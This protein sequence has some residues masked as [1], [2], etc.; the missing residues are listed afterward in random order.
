MK[1]FKLSVRYQ[2]ILYITTYLPIV[3]WHWSRITKTNQRSRFFTIFPNPKRP[4]GTFQNV[5]FHVSHNIIKLNRRLV[6]SEVGET[7]KP[8]SQ[9]TF[10]VKFALLCSDVTSSMSTNLTIQSVSYC[11]YLCRFVIASWSVMTSYCVYRIP[12][13]AHSTSAAKFSANT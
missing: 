4:A 9:C 2:I 7:Q 12:L 1:N 8:R 3:S 6:L 5:T 11:I 10:I 13:K